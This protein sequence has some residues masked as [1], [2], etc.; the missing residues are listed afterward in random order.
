[1]DVKIKLSSSTDPRSEAKLIVQ[2]VEESLGS[3]VNLTISNCEGQ[4]TIFVLMEDLRHALRK[5]AA[6]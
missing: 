1:M 4:L 3:E 2:N 5:I 6:K